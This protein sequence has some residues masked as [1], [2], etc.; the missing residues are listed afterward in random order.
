MDSGELLISTDA[1]IRIF[2]FLLFVPVGLISYWRLIPRLTPAAKRLASGMLAAQ[3][4]DNHFVA[5]I[6]TI[7]EFWCVALAFP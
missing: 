5:G 4:S 2:L 1:L 6:T 7:F 3:V